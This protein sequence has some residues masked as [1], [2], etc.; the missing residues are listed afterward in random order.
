MSDPGSPDEIFRAR[1]LS[2]YPLG[3]GRCLV[4]ARSNQAVAVLPLAL[5]Q[6]LVR[7][8]R[9][10]SLP[11]HAGE[12]LNQLQLAPERRGPLTDELLGQLRGLAD[13]GLLVSSGQLLRLCQSAAQGRRPPEI[14]TLAVVTRDRVA[15]SERCLDSYLRSCRQHGRK[16][17]FLLLDDSESAE[18]QQS[19][20]QMLAGL[21][22][23]YERP[24]RYAGKAEKRRFAAELQRV[25]QLPQ[26]TIEFALGDPE[27]IGHTTGANRNWMLLATVGQLAL[28]AD[29]DTVCQ[30]APSPQQEP[31]LTLGAGYDAAELWPMPDAAAVAERVSIEDRDIVALHEGLLGKDLASCIADTAGEAEVGPTVDRFIE[32]IESGEGRVGLTWTGG[33]G[34]SGI[35]YPAYCLVPS[36]AVRPHLLRSEEGY[37]AAI[38]SRQILR[39][40]RR[41]TALW[42]SLL[43]TQLIGLDNRELLPPYFPVLRGQDLIFA[44]VFRFA[45]D[46]RCVG[47]LPWMV[48]HSPLR[49]RTNEPD[50]IWQCAGVV[51]LYSILLRC[52]GSVVGQRGP[53]HDPRAKL[54]SLGSHLSELGS[55]PGRDFI[56]FL[57]VQLWQAASQSA[58]VLDRML[59]AHR[60]A[61][62]Y[63]LTDVQRYLNTQREAMRRPEYVLPHE[64]RGHGDDEQRRIKTQRLLHRFGELLQAWPTL[65]DAAQTLHRQ[66]ITLA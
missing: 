31:G 50:S 16:I 30:V 35:S 52:I 11:Q 12:L 55:L 28:C 26:D 58:L 13:A 39:F 34:D 61:P 4:Y 9:F 54:K 66:G 46:S 15:E 25:S 64:L 27:G 65:V 21:Q 51:R 3:E 53:Q 36:D 47:Y 14:R 32:V 18:T 40:S 42:R 8:Q 20:Q 23:R 10:A 41:S 29:D 43:P 62:H 19:Y 5:A 63:W 7:A 49:Q 6:G 57:R 17:D 22:A 56:E 38:A 24:V 60:D 1:D 45:F 33:Y 2:L 48:A 44:A 59:S 37:R